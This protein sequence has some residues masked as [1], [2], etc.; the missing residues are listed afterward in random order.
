MIASVR[1]L[2]HGLIPTVTLCFVLLM[3]PSTA[4]CD[5]VL[6]SD[7]FEDGNADNW[8]IIEFGEWEV[9]DGQ[10]CLLTV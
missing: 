3:L 9:A 7:D 5:V 8:E 10:Y 1:K 2:L 6:F 4:F